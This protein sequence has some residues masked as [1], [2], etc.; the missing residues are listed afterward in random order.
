MKLTASVC[1]ILILSLDAGLFIGQDGKQSRGTSIDWPAP[2]EDLGNT[3]RNK[4]KILL[5]PISSQHSYPHTSSPSSPAG[6]V[7]SSQITPQETTAS[8][9]FISTPVLEIRSSISLKPVQSLPVPL[10][11]PA[12]GAPPTAH[13]QIVRLLTSSPGC[14]SPLYLVTTP[15]D[16]TMANTEGSTIV[17]FHMKPWRVQFDELVEAESYTEALSLLETLDAAL[18]P[19]KVIIKPYS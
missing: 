7:P 9:S 1:L 12:E 19:E 18:L 11:P 16:R 8:P 13:N 4:N 14:K 3:H 6:T 10:I 2:P 17:Q 15:S 5:T